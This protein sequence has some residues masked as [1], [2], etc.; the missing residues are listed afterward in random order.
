LGRPQ[1]FAQCTQS[2]KDGGRAV[3]I[4]LAKAGS[5]GEVDINRLVRRKV[6]NLYVC[7]FH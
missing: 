7:V 1:T 5:L 4:G 2:V 6:S 3:M